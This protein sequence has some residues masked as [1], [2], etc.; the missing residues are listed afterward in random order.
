MSPVAQLLAEA[1]ASVISPVAYDTAWV[2]RLRQPDG[3]VRFPETLRW[4]R[5]AQHADGSWGAAAP[6]DQQDRVLSTLAAC[7]ALAEAGAAADQP[8]LA[9]ATAW[10]HACPPP[11]C[12]AGASAGFEVLVPSLAA[13]GLAAGLCLPAWL[14]SYEPARQRRLARLARL[15]RGL[16]TE[17]SSAHYALEGWLDAGIPDERLAAWAADDGLIFGSPAAT[18]AILR[19]RP[20]WA[21]RVPAATATLARL[22]AAGAGGIP[23]LVPYDLFARIRVI[24]ALTA[25]GV[26]APTDPRLAPDLAAITAAWTEPG[27]GFAR[28]MLPDAD[29]TALALL[30]LAGAGH[31][32]PARCLLAYERPGWIATY[33]DEGSPSATTN[34]HVLQATRLLPAA[35][36]AR[37][38]AKLVAWL[39]D[40]GPIWGDKWHRSPAYATSTA[41]AVLAPL[42]PDRLAAT[43]QWVLATQQA[44]GGWGQG[45]STHEE[46]ALF[47]LGLCHYH[48]HVA[49]LPHEVL[50]RGAAFLA[51]AQPD[52]PPALWVGKVLYHPRPVV[53]SLVL[54]ATVATRRLLATSGHAEPCHGS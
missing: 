16:T 44:D 30:A 20:A 18:A 8:R 52:P 45:R 26:I 50:A 13:A 10:L 12:D 21:Q 11:D 41:L 47:L 31:P 35:E 29:D 34:L 33:Q 17:L 32:A 1:R 22:V 39:Q 43:C 40:H 36:A 15:G 38:R 24:T 25:G 14:A 27:I 51:T 37:L 48:A 9:A 49:P 7:V 54:A 3:T 19:A 46:T 28:G 23:P 2:A 53:A 5:R 4:L 6:V 42:V